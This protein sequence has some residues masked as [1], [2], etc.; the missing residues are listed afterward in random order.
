M[1]H[2][3]PRR[4]GFAPARGTR[5]GSARVRACFPGRCNCSGSGGRYMCPMELNDSIEL[6][7]MRPYK[8]EH[9]ILPYAFPHSLLTQIQNKA[10]PRLMTPGI[11]TCVQ[12]R[13]NLEAMASNLI[14]MASNLIAMASNLIASLFGLQNGTPM[15]TRSPYAGAREPDKRFGQLP[16]SLSVYLLLGAADASF[17]QSVGFQCDHYK[18]CNFLGTKR[19]P[20]PMERVTNQPVTLRTV[21]ELPHKT[22][23]SERLQSL[24]WSLGVVSTCSWP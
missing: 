13:S 23:D 9:T 11:G 6:C 22:K 15:V 14:G 20:A 1:L 4:I 3:A 2:R 10:T 18:P 19:N 24:E 17:A 21:A 5:W 12:R 7:A 16:L 8:I